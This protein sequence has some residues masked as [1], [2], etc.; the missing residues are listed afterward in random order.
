MSA[1][2]RVPKSFHDM[3]VVIDRAQ[4]FRYLDPSQSRALGRNGPVTSGTGSC[5]E[6]KTP[7]LY[8]TKEETLK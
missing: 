6:E 7:L 2:G 8:V 5:F 3:T 1:E 4:N